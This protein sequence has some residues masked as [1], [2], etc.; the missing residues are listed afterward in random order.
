MMIESTI[1]MH[2]AI[3]EKLEKAS[4]GTGLSKQRIISWLLKRLADENII[5]LA[6]WSRIR[7]QNRDRKECWHR[8]HIALMPVEYELLLDLKKACKLSGSRIVAYAIERY[9][10]DLLSKKQVNTDNYRFTNYIILYGTLHNV[11]YCM[12]YWGIPLTQSL[13]LP[14]T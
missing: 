3:L 13:P 2:I 7:Y 10:D 9:L 14:V 12:Q 5:P 8:L 4:A 6:P 1:N 11:A